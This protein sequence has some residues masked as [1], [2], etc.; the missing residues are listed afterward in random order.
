M[1]Y[2]MHLKSAEIKYIQRKHIKKNEDQR[3]R[4]HLQIFRDTLKVQLSSYQQ[5]LLTVWEQDQTS[6]Y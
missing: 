3:K 4:S 6:S 5:K 2:C 1:Q